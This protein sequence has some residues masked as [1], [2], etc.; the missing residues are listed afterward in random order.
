M[1]IYSSNIISG[2]IFQNIESMCVCVCMYSIYISI[3][4]GC[5]GS[6]NSP[7]GSVRHSCV[8]VRYI[9]DTGGGAIGYVAMLEMF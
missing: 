4:M 2:I 1:F 6:E 8:T 9:F 3:Y 7:F 5:N